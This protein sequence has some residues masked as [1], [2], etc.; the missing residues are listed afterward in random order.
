M[1]EGGSR[2]AQVSQVPLSQPAVSPSVPGRGSVL[3]VVHGTAPPAGPGGGRL[4]PVQNQLQLCTALPSCLLR[5][6]ARYQ[7]LPTGAEAFPALWSELHSQGAVFRAKHER[8]IKG[9][10][11][12][13]SV[14]ALCLWSLNL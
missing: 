10:H 3:R 13:V 7:R 6:V 1:D 14:P 4:W 2:G 9:K 8:V 12:W 11:T 5:A